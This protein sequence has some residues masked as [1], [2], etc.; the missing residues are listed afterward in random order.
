MGC[1]FC[2]YSE[3]NYKPETGKDFICSQCFQNLI[4]G[5]QEDLKQAHAIA[6]EKGF[7]NKARAIESFLIPEE[8]NVRKAKKPKRI[9]VRKK[10]MRVVRP[11]RDKIRT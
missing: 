1:L 9:T 3:P 7:T 4:A 11:S 6:I 8:I 10:P 5:D 2:N